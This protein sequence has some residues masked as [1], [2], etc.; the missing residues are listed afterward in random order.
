LRRSDA[1]AK[2]SANSDGEEEAAVEAR[3]FDFIVG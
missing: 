3:G 1:A 2:D